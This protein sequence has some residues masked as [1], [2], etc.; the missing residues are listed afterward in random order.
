MDINKKIYVAG[1][2]GMVGSA[3]MRKLKSI[4][5]TN[6]I[7]KDI[8]ELDLTRQSQVE[9]FFEKEKPDVVFLVAANVGGVA[10]NRQYPAEHLS[11]NAY[12]ELNVI[13]SAFKNGCKQL[14]F[15][16]SNCIYPKNAPLPLKEESFMDGKLDPD[17]E[18]YGISKIVGAKLC[19]YYS[20]QYGVQYISAVPCN[21]YGINDCYDEK[22]SRVVAALIRRFHEAKINGYES[23]EIWGDGTALRE[24]LFADDLAD[25]CVFLMDKY[26]ESDIIN[27]SPGIEHSIKDIALMIKEAVGYDGEIVFNTDKPGGIHRK[28]MSCE[29]LHKLGWTAKTDMLTGVNTAYEWF[30]ENISS[31]FAGGGKL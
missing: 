18:G 24:F 2:S 10:D 11:D 5:C 13:N 16:S 19:E 4:G 1:H 23:V 27:V 15:I 14:L 7:G 8:N 9:E 28:N 30:C 25:A 26:Y 6:I 21:L 12:I 29:K 31:N 20:K 17:W 3:L 22:K